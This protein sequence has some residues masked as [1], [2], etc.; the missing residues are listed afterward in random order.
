M[1]DRLAGQNYLEY[2]NV[3]ESIKKQY[4]AAIPFDHLHYQRIYLYKDKAEYSHEKEWRL[5]D[6]EPLNSSEA[7]EDFF[8]IKDSNCLKAIY[9]GPEMEPRYKSHLREIAKLKG[10]KEYDVA[11]VTNSQKYA[12]T[13]IPI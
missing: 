3:P 13:I 9:Y 12:L 5:L 10:I 6:V 7:K 4:A 11:L 2:R 1:I 8:E